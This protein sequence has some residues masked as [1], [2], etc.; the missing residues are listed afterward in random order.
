MPWSKR[1]SYAFS[2]AYT[3][4]RA[5]LMTA[6]VMNQGSDGGGR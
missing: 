3:L 1:R 2:F 6:V 4:A 5:L